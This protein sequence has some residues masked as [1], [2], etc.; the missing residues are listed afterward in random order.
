MKSLLAPQVRAVER[1]KTGVYSDILVE[2]FLDPQNLGWIFENDGAGMAGD[3]SCGDFIVVSIS[4]EDDKLKDIKF[5]VQGCPAAIAVGSMMTV[6]AK[7]KSLDEALA[8]TESDV[9]DALGGL[10]EAKLHCSTLAVEAL[11]EAIA[12]ESYGHHSGAA[13]LRRCSW[14]NQ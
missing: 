4:V 12:A 8:I 6:L 7:G 2:H 9:A 10:S 5:Q 3:P 1:G 13:S 11:R 14:A